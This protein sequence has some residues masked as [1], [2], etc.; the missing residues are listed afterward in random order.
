MLD[1]AA[2]VFIGRSLGCGQG[3]APIDAT[4]PSTGAVFAQFTPASVAQVAEAAEAAAGAFATWR[5]TSGDERAGFLR[6][7][8]EGLRARKAQLVAL[9]MLTAANPGSRP[10]STSTTPPPRSTITPVLRK[11]DSR[12]Q[13]AIKAAWS[14]AR[15]G[16]LAAATYFE[17]SVP[18]ALRVGTSRWSP[19]ATALPRLRRWPGCTDR[20]VETL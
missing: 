19:H 4:D 10:K 11:A 7:I 6:A 3:S 17:R 18:L 15:P 16:C 20:R 2:A 14:C 13:F 5:R 1:R 9:Q 12:P 8:A